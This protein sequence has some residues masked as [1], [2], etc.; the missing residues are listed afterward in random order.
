MNATGNKKAIGEIA[1]RM[2]RFD[3][4]VKI[5][6]A[7][8]ADGTEIINYAD[9]DAIAR[10]EQVNEWDIGRIN[11]YVRTLKSRKA[12]IPLEGGKFKLNFSQDKKEEIE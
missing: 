1:M 9:L 6:K 10:S 4:M 5:L 2:S 12:L 8:H 7:L 3:K 11:Q